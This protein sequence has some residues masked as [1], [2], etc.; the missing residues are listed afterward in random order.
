MQ[1]RYGTITYNAEELEHLKTIHRES[2]CHNCNCEDFSCR[3]C[4]FGAIDDI[5]TKKFGITESTK[6]WEE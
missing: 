4:P 2:L 3:M 5:L 1:L 6:A